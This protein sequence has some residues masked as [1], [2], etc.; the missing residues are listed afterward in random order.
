MP[1][2][3]ANR[4]DRRIKWGLLVVS[5][6]TL[7][8]LTAAALRENV[9]AEWRL[10]RA[11]YAKI[12]KDKA[13]DERGQNL[14]DQ[15]EVRIVQNVL[16]ELG[17]IDRCMTC[18]P[19][20][21]D[22]RMKETAQPYRTHPGDYLEHHPPEKYGCTICHH[23]QGRALTF[24]EAK[25]E[26]HHWDYPLLPKNLTQSSCG[27]CHSAAEVKDHGGEKYALG[28][29]L[30]QD[31]GCSSCHKLKGRG[32]SMGPSLDNVG[33]K[34]K[35]QMLM[36]HVKGPHTLPQWLFEHFENPQAVVP[37]STMK[38]PQLSAEE[39]E[40]LTVYMLSLQKRDLPRTY[41][42]PDRHLEYYKEAHPD[43]ET[44][45]EL[46]NRYCSNCHD[47]GTYGRYDPF[48]VKF[49]P[50]IRG[51]TFVQV[52][53]PDYVD[54][55][56]L[57]GRPG[58]LM[59]PW[60]AEAGGLQEAEVQR[61]REFLLSAPVSPGATIHPETLAALSVVSERPGDALRGGAIFDKQC[62]GCHGINGAGKL[63]PALVNS[64]FQGT[65]SIAFIYTT[66]ALGRSNTAMP[67]FLAPDRGGLAENDIADLTAYVRS[68]SLGSAPA[69][70]E[71]KQSVAALGQ[72]TRP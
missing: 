45:E 18:H 9:Y 1:R 55:N 44:G 59:P 68:L 36:A 23:G 62:A 17:T 29:Q 4:L 26:G 54:Q 52:A 3:D 57:K 66:I 49:I 20:I 22:P 32:G 24:E 71:H 15:F 39:N 53:S 25:A 41:L 58:T 21:D 6:L 12:L 65:A 47:T 64:V 16:P 28:S 14:A 31:K 40:A 5:L 70:A 8:L 69:L 43:P 30:Y 11:A 10:I 34:V 2:I 63:A 42:S 33:M 50:A 7:G 72:E 51:S 60:S 19:G 56:I 67:A 35:G 38:P 61:I 27:L 37:G 13:V 46:Y 48:F